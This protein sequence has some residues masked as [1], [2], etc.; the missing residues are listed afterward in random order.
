[1]VGGAWQ[2]VFSDVVN[3]GI[4]GKPTMKYMLGYFVSKITLTSKQKNIDG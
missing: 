3:T 4:R 2:R 1:M